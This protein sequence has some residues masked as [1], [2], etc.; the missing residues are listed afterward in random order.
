MLTNQLDKVNHSQYLKESS[1]SD[2]DTIVIDE[3]EIKTNMLTSKCAFAIH[4]DVL[5][6]LYV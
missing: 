3:K 2:V 1:D 6:S 5:H 4:F